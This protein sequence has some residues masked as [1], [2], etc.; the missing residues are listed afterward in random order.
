MVEK[1]CKAIESLNNDKATRLD[2]LPVEFNK[3]AID[4]ISLDLL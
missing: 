4:W 1:I 2:G 3:S